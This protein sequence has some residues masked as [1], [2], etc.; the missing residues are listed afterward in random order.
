VGLTGSI[1]SS[2]AA[3][4]KEKEKTRRFRTNGHFFPDGDIAFFLFRYAPYGDIAFFLFRYAPLFVR[5]QRAA[6]TYMM[7]GA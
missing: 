3:N 7:A 6:A 5:N 4:C 2:T 1:L